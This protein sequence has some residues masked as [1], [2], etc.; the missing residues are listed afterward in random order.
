V[1]FQRVFRP[2]DPWAVWLCAAGTA[3][4]LAWWGLAAWDG[5]SGLRGEASPRTLL[6]HFGRLL[7]HGWGA[8][9]CFRYHRTMQRRVGVGLAEP[10][11]AHQFWLWGLSGAGLVVSVLVGVWAS[12]VLQ[13]NVLTW[14]FGL[15]ALSALGLVS[16]VSMWWAFFPP[17]F[18]RRL[19]LH[20]RL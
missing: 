14:P 12:Y 6:Y 15:F 13:V 17:A 4:L 10:L 7:I 5:A 19:L 9:E 3:S 8:V 2:S 11:V 16:A 18:Y 20:G 1:G